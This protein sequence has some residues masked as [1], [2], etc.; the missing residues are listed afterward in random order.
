MAGTTRGFADG[1]H[2]VSQD[3]EEIDQTR[4]EGSIAKLFER[5]ANPRQ[6]IENYFG[7]KIAP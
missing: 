1:R 6:R 7:V 3:S 2:K 5:G 4:T